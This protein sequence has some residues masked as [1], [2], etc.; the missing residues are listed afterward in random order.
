MTFV[1]PYQD[2]SFNYT[3]SRLGRKLV[4][5]RYLRHCLSEHDLY[6]IEPVL[7]EGTK[8]GR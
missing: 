5:R 7:V 8:Y 1:C 4:S 2:Y 3:D 6:F